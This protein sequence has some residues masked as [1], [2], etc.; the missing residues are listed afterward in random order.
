MEYS[1]SPFIPF[2]RVSITAPGSQ[3]FIYSVGLD[4]SAARI[5]LG[6]PGSALSTEPQ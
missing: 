5:T 3:A 6:G 1:L 2:S 4:G